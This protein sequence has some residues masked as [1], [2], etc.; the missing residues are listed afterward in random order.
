MGKARTEKPEENPCQWL[1]RQRIVSSLVLR[2]TACDS[3]ESGFCYT[4]GKFQMADSNAVMCQVWRG[5]L[6]RGLPINPGHGNMATVTCTGPKKLTFGTVNQ[7]LVRWRNQNMWLKRQRRLLVQLSTTKEIIHTIYRT[8]V[9]QYT[10]GIQGVIKNKIQ[11]RW[12]CGLKLHWGPK[13]NN[14][15]D[16]H[17]THA[18]M[19]EQL[20]E[21]RRHTGLTPAV[22]AAHGGTV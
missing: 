9:K 22:G 12:W 2:S 5:L 15:G 13:P 14:P 17:K 10:A 8:D 21:P 6:A 7:S 18:C 19:H 11:T 16:Y 1:V 20:L 3:P 4:G